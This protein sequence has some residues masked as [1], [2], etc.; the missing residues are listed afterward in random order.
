MLVETA[1]AE[2]ARRN[3]TRIADIGTGTGAIAI[4]IAAHAPNA[5]VTAID[6]SAAALK[7]CSAE[8]GARRRC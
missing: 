5:Q 8:R 1:L 6:A 2:V 7:L 3:V 4:A